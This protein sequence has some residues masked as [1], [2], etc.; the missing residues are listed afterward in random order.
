[1]HLERPLVLVSQCSASGLLFV[2]LST[3]SRA[4]DLRVRQSVQTRFRLCRTLML[5]QSVKA[6][7][8]HKRTPLSSVVAHHGMGCAIL[9]LTILWLNI[10]QPVCL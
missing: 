8:R 9:V 3:L 4:R 5:H 7:L 6:L 10:D 1:M 2:L